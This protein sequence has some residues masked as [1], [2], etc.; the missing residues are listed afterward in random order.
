MKKVKRRTK[1]REGINNYL[2]IVIKRFLM[3]KGERTKCFKS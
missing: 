1:K 3:I 2:F